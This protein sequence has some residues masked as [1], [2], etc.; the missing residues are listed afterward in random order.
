MTDHGLFVVFNVYVPNGSGGKRLPYK[1][2]WLWALRC[3]MARQR[4]R[5]KAVL[6]VGALN[7]KHRDMD[8]PWYWQSIEIPRFITLA[9]SIE[10]EEWQLVKDAAEVVER[11]WP[12]IMQCLQQREHPKETY[13]N[14]KNEPVEKWRVRVPVWGRK[15]DKAILGKPYFNESSAQTSYYYEGI[16]VHEDGSFVLGSSYHKYC[17]HKFEAKCNAVQSFRLR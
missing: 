12:R 13:N 11:A 6:L 5:G 3:A 2:R 17:I 4:Q 15:G 14:A 16:G 7:L 1:S 8:T 9:K 10:Q